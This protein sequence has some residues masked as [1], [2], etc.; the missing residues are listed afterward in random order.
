MCTECKS[1]CF[2]IEKPETG[3]VSFTVYSPRHGEAGVPDSRTGYGS[4]RDE[5]FEDCLWSSYVDNTKV[6]GGYTRAEL[7]I[8]FDKV[9]D[10]YNWKN[11]IKNVEVSR[12]EVRVIEFAIAFYIGAF[13]TV[14]FNPSDKDTKYHVSSPG[15]YAVCGA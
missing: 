13:P 15:Y 8:A 7:K 4:S 14:S 5:A 2:K 1:Y 6:F 12:D 10:K 11:P 3:K 9:C